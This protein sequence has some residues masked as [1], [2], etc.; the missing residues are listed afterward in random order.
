M[1]LVIS[2][3]DYRLSEEIAKRAREGDL[4]LRTAGANVNGLRRYLSGLDVEEVLYLPHTDCAAL[5]LVYSAIKEGR[6]V[7]PA[8]EEAL[9]SLYRGREFSTMEELERIH[10]ELQTSILKSLFPRAKVSVE[11]IDVSKV[12]P[13]QR[14]PVYHLL[15]PSSRYD[16]EALGAY[17]IQAPKREDVEAD[18]KI[19]E[20]LGLRPGRSEI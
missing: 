7:D 20:S 12:K 17:I 2:C 10:V 15:K 14:K 1:R 19:A 11:I 8:V 6:P 3:M 16:Q 4:I 5:K 9:V 13:L 18:I